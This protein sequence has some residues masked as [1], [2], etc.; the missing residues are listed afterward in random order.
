[1]KRF[2]SALWRDDAGQDLT[3]YVMLVVIIA[4]GVTLAV[5]ALRDEL[6]SVFFQMGGSTN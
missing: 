4:L 2:F 5:V 1:M 3:E 6:I